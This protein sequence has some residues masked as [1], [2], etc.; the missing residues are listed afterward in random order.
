MVETSI[1][2]QACRIVILNEKGYSYEKWFNVKEGTTVTNYLTHI[3][4]I[5]EGDLEK[6]AP[7]NQVYGEKDQEEI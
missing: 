3:T 1:G 4:G 2:Q 7:L 5:R 6:K